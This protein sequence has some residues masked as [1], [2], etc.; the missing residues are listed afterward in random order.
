MHTPNSGGA[1]QDGTG[2]TKPRSPTQLMYTDRDNIAPKLWMGAAPRHADLALFDAVVLCAATLQH[3][4]VPNPILAPLDDAVP[5]KAELRIALNAARRVHALTEDGKRVLVTCRLGVN[6]SGLV[7]AL[8]LMLRGMK[9]RRA[10]R[11]IR[12][13]RRPQSGHTPL[14]ND[15]FVAALLDLEARRPS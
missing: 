2:P 12:S 1:A 14:C 8:A 6:R 15:A 10:V 9:A 7:C 3:L 13:R 4:D 11:L 5:T